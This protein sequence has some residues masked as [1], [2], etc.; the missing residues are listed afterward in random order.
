VIWFQIQKNER[1]HYPYKMQVRD[2]FIFLL[3]D[4]EYCPR[5]RRAIARRYNTARMLL[6]TMGYL[7]S[8]KKGRIFM[9]PS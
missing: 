9:R 3:Q 7:E 5:Q 1:V 6:L 2:H 4:V 8:K